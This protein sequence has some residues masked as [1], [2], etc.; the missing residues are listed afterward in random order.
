L[1]GRLL[2]RTLL[3]V[4]AGWTWL[5][6]AGMAP[7]VAS[8]RREEIASHTRAFFEWLQVAPLVDRRS[9]ELHALSQFLLGIPADIGWR[10]QC[11]RAALSLRAAAEGFVAGAILAGIILLLPVAVTVA[12]EYRLG[13]EPGAQ[14][15]IVTALV[16][17]GAL[18][19]LIAPGLLAFERWPFPG[20][21]LVVLGASCVA[22][23]LWW[24]IEAVLLCLA[25]IVAAIGAGN[26]LTKSD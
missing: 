13:S 16:L 2:L 10:A 5:Y 6:T 25:G 4:E 24:F 11:G 7:E 9:A 22:I 21:A 3:S 12:L 15:S 20:T 8:R 1:S 26:R 17:V 14:L 19:L 18:L 23:V